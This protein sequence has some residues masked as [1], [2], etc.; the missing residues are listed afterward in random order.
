MD[1]IIKSE[2]KRIFINT[3]YKNISDMFLK[4]TDLSTNTIIEEGV[5][6]KE[7]N[8]GIYYCDIKIDETGY[9]FLEV[10]S[11]TI[12]KTENIKIVIKVVP[13]DKIKKIEEVSDKSRKMQTNKAVISDDGLLVTIYDDDGIT[14]LHTFNVSSNQKIREPV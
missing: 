11:N 2:V 10:N 1:S 3:F 6:C 9:Y 14:V 13:Y 5:V 4:I 8:P 7:I 12:S